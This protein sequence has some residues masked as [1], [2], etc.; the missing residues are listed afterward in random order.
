MKKKLDE[1]Y[2]FDIDTDLTTLVAKK[3]GMRIE[4]VNSSEAAQILSQ[5]TNWCIKDKRIAD[6]YFKM[7]YALYAFSAERGSANP[8]YMMCPDWETFMNRADDE[9]QVNELERVKSVVMASGVPAIKRLWQKK[10][11]T[12]E[13]SAGEPANLFEAAVDRLVKRG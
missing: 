12:A 9:L 1:Y 10:M 3:D 11:Q 4:K 6:E 8:V 2:R 5:D 7:G 13:D